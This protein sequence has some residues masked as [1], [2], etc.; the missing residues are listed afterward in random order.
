MRPSRFAR[1]RFAVTLASAALSALVASIALR[2][3]QAPTPPRNI[4]PMA[5]STIAMHPEDHY[6]E[7]VSVVAAVE[8][9]LSKT[10]FS[11]D[12]DRAQA[13]GREVLVIVPTLTG[14]VEPN[15][16]VTVVG[17]VVK[18]DPDDIAKR[19]K[20]YTID[21]APEI[22]EKFRG[23]P[24]IL[25]S[26]V[27]T[28][29]LADVAKRPPPPLT[30]EE[31]AFDKTMKA[32]NTSWTALRPAV[33][34]SNAAD[35]KQHAATLKNAFLE[36]QLFFKTRG[37]A[38]ATGWAQDAMKLAGAIEQA[39]A[40][41]KWDDARTSVTSLQPMCATCHAAHRERGEDGS[42]RVKGS[43]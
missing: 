29:D 9:V 23:K 12:Q 4:V 3:Q 42:Y 15:M 22:I 36:A 30:P 14:T 19:V 43:R 39:A 35:A 17:E 18:F 7:G 24:A 13:T 2:A 41:A 27:V 32:V 6:G 25:A 33:E 34:A 21:L 16:Y 40:A 26:S 20:G 8:A 10:T 28:P 5:A 38:D 37:V 31:I 11:V 1:Q